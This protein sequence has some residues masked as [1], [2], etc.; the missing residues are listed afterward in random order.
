MPLPSS[1]TGAAGAVSGLAWG[2]CFGVRRVDL[3][4]AFVLGIGG[5]LLFISRL[6]HWLRPTC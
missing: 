4:A 1:L 5:A 2:A 3:P 6:A